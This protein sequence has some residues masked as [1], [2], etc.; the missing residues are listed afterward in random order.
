MP[1]LGELP[2]SLYSLS[3]LGFI[4]RIPPEWE[5][6][7]LS[8]ERA[9]VHFHSAECFRQIALIDFSLRVEEEDPHATWILMRL[10]TDDAGYRKAAIS[11]IREISRYTELQATA[12]SAA[13]DHT[14]NRYPDS[15]QAFMAERIPACQHDMEENAIWETW[16]RKQHVSIGLCLQSPAQVT[17]YVA[18]TDG[19]PWHALPDLIGMHLSVLYIG[20]MV[21]PFLVPEEE[22]LLKAMRKAQASGIDPVIALPPLSPKRFGSIEER[23][24][25]VMTAYGAPAEICV[26]DWGLL[27]LI[28]EYLPAC[29][30]ELGPLLVRAPRDP[31]LSV[32]RPRALSP[33]AS[34]YARHLTELGVRRVA[35]DACCPAPEDLS[36]P[37]S[38]HL[39]FYQTNTAT[40]C[41]LRSAV[42]TGR[43]GRQNW[44]EQ[45][46][47]P[48][49]QYAFLYSESLD[50]TGR[51][52]TLYGLNRTML[53]SPETLTGFM[54]SS[55]DRLVLNVFEPIRGDW[56]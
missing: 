3:P 56:P 11:L 36:L 43:R 29:P 34:F 33:G 51:F 4:F 17:A 38:L 42:D 48:C 22:L 19:Y 14:E 26:N 24:V 8:A 1:I 41:T 28:H 53:E 32:D 10:E 39:P 25:K 37:Y 49:E 2:C 20:S 50:L 54:G 9:E 44:Y 40:R 21:C 5:K 30:V 16:L 6:A 46:E 23:L 13:P 18:N 55:C 47:R 7:V 31:R 15:F 45:C 27:A 35:L 12:F 52:N